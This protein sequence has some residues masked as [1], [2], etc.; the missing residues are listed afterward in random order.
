MTLQSS[1]AIS[2]SQ[3]RTEFNKSGQTSLSDY[4]DIVDDVPASGALDMSDFY[5]RQRKGKLHAI[6]LWKS[7]LQSAKSTGVSS[8]TYV[9]TADYRWNYS[10][11]LVFCF[12]INIIMNR[13]LVLLDVNI[14]ITH[15]G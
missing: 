5:G 3:L 8:L 9:G 13:T 10:T 11:T 2:M 15:I 1:G 12:S 7:S 14:D 4:Y 6:G